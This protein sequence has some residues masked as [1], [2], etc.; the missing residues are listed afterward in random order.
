MI[1]MINSLVRECTQKCGS[2]FTVL[3]QANIEAYYISN[4]G[5]GSAFNKVEGVI[6]NA[7]NYRLVIARVLFNFNQIAG[8]N[9]HFKK[10]GAKLAV[11]HVYNKCTLSGFQVCQWLHSVQVYL[12]CKRRK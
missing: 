8:E 5:F 1:F 10:F 3:I 2:Y 7:D 6:V 11:S 4:N 12:Q 9:A